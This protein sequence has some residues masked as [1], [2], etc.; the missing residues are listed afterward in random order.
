MTRHVQLLT[1]VH[2]GNWYVPRGPYAYFG[3][4]PL[5][6][7]RPTVLVQGDRFY[8]RSKPQYEDVPA[9]NFLSA[10]TF[11]AL[12]DGITDDTKALNTLFLV[13]A[14]RYNEGVV[15][16]LDAGYY[17]VSDTVNILSNIRLVGEGMS[18]VILGAGASFSDIN[19]PRA[20]LQIGS[21]SQLA[22]VEI[23][24]IFVSTQGGT[25]GAILIEYNVNTPTSSP[26]SGLWD[27]HVRVGGFAGS[28]LQVAQCPKTPNVATVPHPACVAAY[29]SFHITRTAGNLYVENSWVWVAD[30]DIEDANNTQINIFAGRG[31]LVESAPGRIWLVATSV[32]HHTLY[33]YQLLNTRDIW[34]GQIQ[35]ET[36]YYQPNPPAP[37]PFSTVNIALSDPDFASICQGSDNTFTI[38]WTPTGSPSCGMAWGLRVLNSRNVVIFGAGLYSF[39]NNYDTHCSTQTAGERCQGRIF[40]AEN[41]M[42]VVYNLDTIGSVSMVTHG[43]TDLASWAE[44]FATFASTVAVLWL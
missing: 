26:P 4:Q 36:P 32:E 21:P 15:V 23:S 22:Y 16:F 43:G 24:D 11:G 18:S 5:V 12:G 30:H 34:M 2:Q 44:N 13:G 19:N 3:S 6:F 20:V 33:Q 17:K 14:L 10:R 28:L 25:A 35:T 29:M 8:E 40:W 37:A 38:P 41:D 1:D 27:V 31:L 9:S 7:P 42:G 39:F